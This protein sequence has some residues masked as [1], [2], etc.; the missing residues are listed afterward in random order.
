MDSL[1]YQILLYYKYTPIEDPVALRDNQRKLCEEL[2]LK[3]R[4]IVAGEGINGTVEGTVE[5][6]EKYIAAMIADPRF[7]DIV[8]KRSEGT[9]NSFPKLS[10]KARSEIVSANLGEDD[11]KPWEMTGKYLPPDELK[12]WFENEKVGQD[13][14]VI[15]MRNDYE[16]KSG[17]FKDSVLP[18]LH[19]FRDLPKALPD[20]EKFKDKKVLTVCTGGVRCEKAS[21]YLVKKGFK[22]VYQL[23]DGIVSYMEKYPNQDFLGKLYVFDE[24]HTVGFNT[25]SPEHVVVGKCDLCA[26]ACDDYADCADPMCNRHF[27]ACAACRNENGEAFCSDE[28]RQSLVAVVK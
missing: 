21:G 26:A 11:V 19:N 4:I 5:N 17:Y 14:V 22:D 10:I 7:A 20:L 24:R 28:C 25:D 27:I 15:D 9:G 23:Q 2:G 6:T 8:W 1:A 18:P 3:G 13:F 12:K 16:F